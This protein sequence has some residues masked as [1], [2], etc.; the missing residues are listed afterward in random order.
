MRK[1]LHPMTGKINRRKALKSGLAMAAVMLTTG[2]VSGAPAKKASGTVDEN[3]FPPKK[4]VRAKPDT[5]SPLAYLEKLANAAGPKLAFG[6][7]NQKQAEQWQKDLRL[8]LW[9]L[10]GENHVPGKIP[11]SARRISNKSLDGYAQ[12]KWVIDTVPGRSMPFYVL[13]PDKIKKPMK[14]ALCLNGHGNGATDVIGMPENQE[15]RDLIR[16]VNYDY[17]LQTVKKGW[18]AVVPELFAFGER[19]DL[20]EDAREGFDGGCE[21]PFLNAVQ[22]G[23]TLIGIRVKDV[24]VLIDW[25]AENKKDFNM[26]NL[27]CIGLS[28]GGT[29]TTF[30]SA[31]DTRIKRSLIAGYVTE[32]SRSILPIRHCSCN[33]VPGLGQ[34]ADIPDICGLIAPRPLVIQT[35]IKDAIFPIDSVR[36]S[37]QKI[38]RVYTVFKKPEN[39]RL[40]EHD[41]Y[42]SFWT[43]SLD[44]VLAY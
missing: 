10:I 32:M 13:V 2:K 21:K 33:Y 17:A 23:K 40:D 15:E 25:L 1:E 19:V 31:L 3:P 42:H 8:K 28:G 37:Y 5:Y 30:L 27:V 6:A 18:C 39:V 38:R 24:A 43:P 34:W 26:D 35:G 29:I 9:G 12:E 44:H 41:G 11:A 22:F 4:I 7:K 14:T 16:L 20:V 36:R